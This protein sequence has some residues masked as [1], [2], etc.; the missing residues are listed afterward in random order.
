MFKAACIEI[1]TETGADET[2]LTKLW[3]KETEK[4]I[5]S[6]K[7][8]RCSRAFTTTAA[9]RSKIDRRLVD[10]YF[11]RRMVLT[12]QVKRL[13]LHRASS[14]FWRI[15]SEQCKVNGNITYCP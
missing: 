14:L 10:K 5:F 6:R 8:H 9:G 4:Q 12:Q 7:I 11:Q 15:Y 1:S 13:K 3:F 2:F